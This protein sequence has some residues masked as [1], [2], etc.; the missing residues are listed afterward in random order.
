MAKPVDYW[1][2]KPSPTL[3]E[4]CLSGVDNQGRIRYNLS[5]DEDEVARLEKQCAYCEYCNTAPCK[6]DYYDAKISEIKDEGFR[7]VY[8]FRYRNDD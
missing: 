7:S 4:T 2:M 1:G 6:C 5:M 3:I 8:A